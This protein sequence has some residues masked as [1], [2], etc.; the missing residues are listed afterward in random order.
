[1]KLISCCSFKGGAGKT[2]ALMGLCSAFATQGKS[3]AL[4]EADENRPLTKWKENAIR[5][6]AWD[7]NCE[8]FIADEMALL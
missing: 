2:T 4:F 6:N 3:V 7:P 8:V 5:H 1:M